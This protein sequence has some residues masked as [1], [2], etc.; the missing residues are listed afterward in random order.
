MNYGLI[1][2]GACSGVLILVLAAAMSA[3]YLRA[4]YS[5]KKLEKAFAGRRP[6]SFQ[7]FHQQYFAKRGIPEFVSV[8]VR[9]VLE[10]ETRFDLSRLAGDDDFHS[11]LSFLKNAVDH[12]DTVNS[13]EK[14]FEI[15]IAESDVATMGSATVEDIVKLVW[16]TLRANKPRKDPAT[17]YFTGR[18]EGTSTN[19]NS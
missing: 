17:I 14:V 16:E 7:E 10:S 15:R 9:K 18:K 1:A 13:L 3:S 19:G 8:G 11:N 4:R 6:L 2:V 5:A 12:P